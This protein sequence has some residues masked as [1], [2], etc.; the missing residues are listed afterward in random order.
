MTNERAAQIRALTIPRMDDTRGCGLCDITAGLPWAGVVE[1]CQM[2]A[3]AAAP[4]VTLIVEAERMAVAPIRAAVLELLAERAKLRAA[5][6]GLIDADGTHEL[7]LATH[8][9]TEALR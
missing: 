6:L 4:L 1:P 9:A 8:A 2:H 5:L 7:F 3:P